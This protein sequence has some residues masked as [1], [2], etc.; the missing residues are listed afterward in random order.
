MLVE[1]V[2]GLEHEAGEVGGGGGDGEGGGG[3]GDGEGGGGLGG[4]SGG[5]E[6]HGGGGLG[7]D[8]GRLDG[9][10]GVGDEWSQSTRSLT[11]FGPL[12]HDLFD[13]SAPGGRYGAGLPYRL[14]FGRAYRY[15]YWPPPIT[16]PP[17]QRRA[18]FEF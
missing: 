1:S 9:G 16:P 17:R 3:G 15:R 8:G 12:N 10:G 7:G 6:G 14:P 4:G 11:G 13:W 5:G 2:H 18:I